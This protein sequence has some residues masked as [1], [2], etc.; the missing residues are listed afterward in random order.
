MINLPPEDDQNDDG[1]FHICVKCKS[2]VPTTDIERIPVMY[3]YRHLCGG[4]LVPYEPPPRRYNP[5]ITGE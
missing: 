5:E 3:R 4:T 1:Q 2:R